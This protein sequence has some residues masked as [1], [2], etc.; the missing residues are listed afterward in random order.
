MNKR[1]LVV[2]DN[3]IN[4]N[5]L[6]MILQDEFDVIEA[7]NGKQALSVIREKYEELSA[8]VLDLLMPEMSGIELM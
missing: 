4:R 8:V 1:I 5:L 7:E 6:K 3:E 2:E